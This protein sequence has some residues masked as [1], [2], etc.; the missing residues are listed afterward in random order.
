MLMCGIRYLKKDKRNGITRWSAMVGNSGCG[1]KVSCAEGHHSAGSKL[2]AS[3]ISTAGC[4]YTG[5]VRLNV[6]LIK[7][8]SNKHCGGLWNRAGSRHQVFL[9]TI[10]A[11]LFILASKRNR[12]RVGYKKD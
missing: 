8:I 1:R 2:T 10:Y 9:K 12:V 6:F 7:F 11:S 4:P 3:A 5:R